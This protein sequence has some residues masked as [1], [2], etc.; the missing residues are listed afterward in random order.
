MEAISQKKESILKFVIIFGIYLVYTKLFALLMGD[1]LITSF[2]GDITFLFGIVILYQTVLI[3]DFKSF[4]KYNIGKKIG[5]VFGGALAIFA[6]NIV[7]GMITE[8]LFPNQFEIDENTDA[9]Y[10]LEMAHAVFKTI[11]FAVIAEELV[12]RKAVRDVVENNFLFVIVSSL[13]YALMNI[14]YASSLDL[15]ASVDLIQCFLFGVLLSSIYVKT[16]NVVVIMLI[17]FVYNLVP[18]TIMIL[19]L[20]V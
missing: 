6:L 4:L 18:L 7:G 11:I 2:V 5:I 13:L 8:L 1:S 20:G 15:N 9:L 17:K 10:Q 14:A 3:K 12:F 16:D 19:G